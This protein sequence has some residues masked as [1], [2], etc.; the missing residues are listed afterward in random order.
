MP[1]APT[2]THVPGGSR[3]FNNKTRLL[4][5]SLVLTLS[6]GYLLYTAFP[7]SVSYYLTVSEFM[8]DE[9]RYGGQPAR[10]VG[11]L[12]PASYIQAPNSLQH[13]F[14][15]VDG[16]RSLNATYNGIVPDLFLNE[17]SDIVLEGTYNGSVFH[18]RGIIVKCPSK[19]QELN[20]EV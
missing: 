11:K 18:A 1:E 13:S 12:E 8:A 16:V 10:V 20:Q 17:H 15:L 5:V 19:Y 9:S 4:M 7:G 6:L 14:T 2:Q 3:L